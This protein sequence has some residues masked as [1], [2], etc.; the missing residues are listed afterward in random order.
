MKRR[1]FLALCAAALFGNRLSETTVECPQAGDTVD[2]RGETLVLRADLK[3]FTFRG[4]KVDRGTITF[5]PDLIYSPAAGW[6]S[7]EG[8]AN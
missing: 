5:Q 1:G 2:Y 8:G 6:T 3:T 7:A 4:C